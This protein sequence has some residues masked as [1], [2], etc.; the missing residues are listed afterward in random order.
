MSDCPRKILMDAVSSSDT[1]AFLPILELETNS[2]NLKKI[3]CA[4]GIKVPLQLLAVEEV[5]KCDNTGICKQKINSPYHNTSKCHIDYKKFAH[6]YIHTDNLKEFIQH[7]VIV[8]VDQKNIEDYNGLITILKQTVKQLKIADKRPYFYIFYYGNRPP[9]D[10]L[11]PDIKRI[12]MKELKTT[13]KDYIENEKFCQF[14]TAAYN[15]E[16]FT[17]NSSN[18]YQFNYS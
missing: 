11:V 18:P 15:T 9:I 6:L 16:N 10:L 8:F 3:E 5:K 1:P 7:Y 2:A 17:I 4:P 12:I 14:H 13:F